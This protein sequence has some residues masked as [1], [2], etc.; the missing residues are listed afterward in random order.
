MQIIF[1]DSDWMYSRE[2]LEYMHF[3][4]C[5]RSNTERRMTWREYNSLRDPF[6]FDAKYDNIILE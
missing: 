1:K 3:D 2:E 5:F 6:D 4:E